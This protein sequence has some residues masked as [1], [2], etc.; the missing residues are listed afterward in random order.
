VGEGFAGEVEQDAKTVG[1]CT[2]IGFNPRYLTDIAAMA[3]G[4]MRMEIGDGSSP[5]RITDSLRPENL[6][7]LMPMRV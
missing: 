4:E 6:F 2:S 1:G 7:V 5:V 3:A